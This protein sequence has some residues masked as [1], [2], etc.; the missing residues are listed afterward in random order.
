MN[1]ETI[2]EQARKTALERLQNLGTPLNR[3][4]L[5]GIFGRV[6]KGVD[7]LTNGQFVVS[8]WWELLAEAGVDN[9]D[10]VD[11]GRPGKDPYSLTLSLAQMPYR[12]LSVEVAIENGFLP[13]N[14]E[15]QIEKD[16]LNAFWNWTIAVLNAEIFCVA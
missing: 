15:N 10:N 13:K 2:L 9:V 5:E 7:T 12:H 16:A 6:A 1:I 14:I 8:R 11:V 4:E 3:E